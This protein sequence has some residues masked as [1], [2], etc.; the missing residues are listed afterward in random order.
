MKKLL[1][2]T[3]PDEF[4]IKSEILD[5]DEKISRR[6]ILCASRDRQIN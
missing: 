4:Q 1:K 2:S 6:I 3:H 5:S